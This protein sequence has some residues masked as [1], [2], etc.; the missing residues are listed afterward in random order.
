MKKSLNLKQ[1]R[2]VTEYLKDQ[3]AKQ[4]AIRAG[5]SKK[6]AETIGPRLSRKV[7]VR[8][9]IETKLQKL[10]EKTLVT[11]E[12]VIGSLK[13][14]ANRC[15]QKVPVMVFDKEEKTLR[16]AVDE[17][18]EGVWEFDSSGANKSL[19]LLGKH[20]G[21]FTEKVDVTSGGRSLVDILREVH[22]DA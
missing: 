9:E 22:G 3:N 20:I 4:A 8:T 12:F 6:N 15:M 10:Q 1:Q 21:A 17:D 19:E 16:Q 11:K 7:Q 2:F 14:I 5:Y 13:E 18:G